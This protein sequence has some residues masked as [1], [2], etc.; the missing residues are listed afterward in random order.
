VV[1]LLAF[2]GGG[3]LIWLHR[4]DDFVS[5]QLESI[6]SQIRE[7]DRRIS[8]T[9]AQTLTAPVPTVAVFLRPGVFRT[10]EAVSLNQ[11]LSLP[12]R[13]AAILVM[14]QLEDDLYPSYS[15]L[16]GSQKAR[17]L[18]RFEAVPS[19]TVGT[20]LRVVSVSLNS[21]MFDP[22]LYNIQLFG[23]RNGDKLLLS[24]YQLSITGRS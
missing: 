22:G 16:V 18:N 6:D 3:V 21:Q 9:L 13:P 8:A 15:V 17:E 23:E 2:T 4:Q 19:T 1:A 10:G 24:V 20:S 5:T 11:T 7:R 14:L 12:A